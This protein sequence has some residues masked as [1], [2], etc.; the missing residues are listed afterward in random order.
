MKFI[1]IVC[2]VFAGLSVGTISVDAKT[3]THHVHKAKH[4][5]TPAPKPTPKPIACSA[6]PSNFTDA[7]VAE[8]VDLHNISP[9]FPST[10]PKA[11]KLETFAQYTPSNLIAY[12]FTATNTIPTTWKYLT[13]IGSDTPM[14]T[15]DQSANYLFLNA[16]N[17]VILYPCY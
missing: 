7:R 11:F 13:I 15:V 3:H 5:P 9:L 6:T 12:Q 1:L 16:Y 4:I 17:G 8:W 10:P 2:L 14:L